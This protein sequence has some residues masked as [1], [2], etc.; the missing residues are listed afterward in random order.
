MLCVLLVSST[1]QSEKEIVLHDA[2]ND[3]VDDIASVLIVSV[4]GFLALLVAFH[5][6]HGSNHDW[7]L[8]LDRLACEARIEAKHISRLRKLLIGRVLR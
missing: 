7:S 8:D 5:L 2:H 1:E 6:V 4:F 3:S